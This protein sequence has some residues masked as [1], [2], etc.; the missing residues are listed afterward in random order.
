MT[1]CGRACRL[2][3]TFWRGAEMYARIVFL[4]GRG[5]TTE[6]PLNELNT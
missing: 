1:Y 6:V 4:D 5:E 2:I 3:T